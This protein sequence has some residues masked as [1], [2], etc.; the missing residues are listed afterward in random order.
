MSFGFKSKDGLLR[1][2]PAARDDVEA[3]YLFFIDKESMTEEYTRRPLYWNGIL[4]A[5]EEYGY[6][7]NELDSFPCNAIH[8]PDVRKSKQARQSEGIYILQNENGGPIKIGQTDDVTARIAQLQTGNPYRLILRRYCPEMPCGTEAM[9][10]RKYAQF[11]LHGEWFDESITPY[12]MCDLSDI[13]NGRSVIA[14][15]T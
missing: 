15:C 9:L 5:L 4:L 14:Q 10:H 7:I 3:W 13:E 1:I 6:R 8:S 12:V 11:N 2:V